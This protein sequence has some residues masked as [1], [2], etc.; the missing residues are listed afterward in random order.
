[1]NACTQVVYINDNSLEG[2][3]PESCCGVL[4]PKCVLH[5]SNKQKLKPYAYI[6]MCVMISH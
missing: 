3:S 2:I 6:Q 4:R 1:M 5:P